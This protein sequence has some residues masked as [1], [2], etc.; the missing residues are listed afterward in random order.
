MKKFG[1]FKFGEHLVIR[2]IRQTF[3]NSPN[4]SK[5]FENFRD[6]M[7]RQFQQWYSEEVE[8]KIKSS[9]NDDEKL[10]DLKLLPVKTPWIEMAG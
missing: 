4:N 5:F 8:K 2:Q 10:I 9:I 7:K 3:P 1:W 6:K